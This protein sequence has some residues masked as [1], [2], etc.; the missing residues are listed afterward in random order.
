ML[1]QPAEQALLRHATTPFPDG[2]TPASGYDMPM[3]PPPLQFVDDPQ[4][5]CL[6][7]IKFGRTVN[8]TPLGL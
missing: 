1:S 8:L 6:P 7:P 2:F 4:L 3:P 5:W